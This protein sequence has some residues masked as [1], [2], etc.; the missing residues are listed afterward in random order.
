MST[1][2]NSMVRSS[3]MTLKR[4]LEVSKFLF[5]IVI[6]LKM[7]SRFIA[8]LL[9]QWD[10]YYCDPNLPITEDEYDDDDENVII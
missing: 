5:T 10:W 3:S 8:A 4:T 1:Q 7:Y 2:A 6:K 9:T